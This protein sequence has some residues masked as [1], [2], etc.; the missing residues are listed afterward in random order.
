MAHTYENI[1]YMQTILHTHATHT[2]YMHTYNTHIYTHSHTNVM[3]HNIYSTHI[4]IHVYTYIHCYIQTR[5][6]YAHT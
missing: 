4:Y 1:P 5:L 2:L 3:T 6:T